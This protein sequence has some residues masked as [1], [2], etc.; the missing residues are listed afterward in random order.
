ATARRVA[1]GEID[2]RVGLG[3]AD[4]VG[5]VAVALDQM[6]ASLARRIERERRFVSDVA[7]ELRTPVAGLVAASD[8]LGDD[9]P[10]RLVRSRSRALARLVD[11]LLEISRLDAGVETADLR[12]VDLAELARFT[13]AEHGVQV[14]GGASVALTDPRRLDRVLTNLLENA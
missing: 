10:A 3:G 14:H 8:L 7:H 4:E 9:E 12:P 11:E 1:A 6:A 13:A 5:A 2:A